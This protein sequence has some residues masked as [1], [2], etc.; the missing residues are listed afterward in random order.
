MSIV[1]PVE[2]PRDKRACAVCKVKPI[3]M[4]ETQVPTVGACVRCFTPYNVATEEGHAL[5]HLTP[6]LDSQVMA[7][8][9]IAWQKFQMQIEVRPFLNS[10]AL[11]HS[12]ESAARDEGVEPGDF[13]VTDFE[14]YLAEYRERE[15]PRPSEDA[16]VETFIVLGSGRDAHWM[17]DTHGGAETVGAAWGELRIDPRV[18]PEGTVVTIVKGGKSGS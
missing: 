15:M 7:V 14:K 4:R 16:R 3:V 13:I 1:W 2:H 8:A 9:S 17:V 12:S 5:E 6:A 11:R 18:L 10:K